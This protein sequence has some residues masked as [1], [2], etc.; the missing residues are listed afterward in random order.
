MPDSII[1]ADSATVAA[2]AKV[3]PEIMRQQLHALA[4]SLSSLMFLPGAVSG[5]IMLV[6]LTAAPGVLL[7][8]ISSW[9]GAV[10]AAALET[11]SARWERKP[12]R[13]SGLWPLRAVMCTATES[14]NPGDLIQ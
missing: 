3:R 12:N 13:L 7:G 2:N 11:L 5:I 8:A 10:L 1:V 4:T 14:H 6:L 9:L